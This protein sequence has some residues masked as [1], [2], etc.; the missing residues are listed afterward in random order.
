LSRDWRRFV[1]AHKLPPV[2][3]H[4]L[5]HSHASALIA[6]GVDPVTVSRRI[7]HANVSTTLNIY[8]HEFAETDAAAAKAIE[9]ALKR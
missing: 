1:L 9:A 5:R 7:G 2:S 4:A 6:S 3:F 8:S